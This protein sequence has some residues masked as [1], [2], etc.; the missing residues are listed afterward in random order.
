LSSLKNRPGQ[1]LT[2]ANIGTQAAPMSRRRGN[3]STV[4]RQ[5]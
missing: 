1:I 2:L 5:Q 4:H 3:N